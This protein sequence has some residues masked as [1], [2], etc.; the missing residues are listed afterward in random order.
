MWRR[1]RLWVISLVRR[2]RFEDELAG[3]LEF[4]LQAR[5]E[6]WAARGVPAAEARRRARLEFGNPD[7]V[8]AEV[9]DVRIGA[10][11]EH[12]AQDARYGTRMLRKHPGFTAM[13]VLSLAIGIG[14]NTA[15]FSLVNAVLLR[16]VPLQRPE[17][18]VDLYFHQPSF[19]FS[20]LSHPDFEDL[21][22]GTRQVF[23]GIGV[24]QLVPAQLDGDGGIEIVLAEAVTGEYLPVLGVEPLLGRL[25][26]PE[27][28]VAP[29]AHP[30][31]ML[32]HS[33]WQS[34]F[35]ADPKVVGRELRIGS[36]AYT[37]IGV[38]PAAYPGSLRGL[39]PALYAPM[40]MLDELMGVPMLANR[41]GHATFGKAR[42]APG[43]TLV[44]AETAAA[45]VAERLDADRPPDWDPG[46]TFALLPTSEVL[47]YPAL[48]P[49]LRAAAWLLL[50]LV[51][52]VLLLA[53]T[54]LAGFLLAR[55][56]DRRREV[57]VRLAIGASRGALMRQLLT[58][59]TLLSAGG[60][61]LGLGLAVSSLKL[62][63]DADLPIPIP[64][65]LTLD[66]S[67]DATVLAFTIGISVLAGAVLGLVPALQ[68][69]RPDLV[70]T[71]KRETAGGAQAGAVRWR[72]ALVVAQLTV[73]MV[74][75]VGA[76]L[77]LRSFQHTLTVDP[78]FGRDP[79]ALMTVMVPLTRFDPDEGR[80]HVNRLMDRFR[81]LP[82]V[83][84]VGLINNLP[85]TPTSVSWF[86]FTVDGYDPPSAQD[87]Y[88]TD[89][90][91]VAGEFFEAAGIAITEGRRFGPE[92]RSDRPPV[93][94][95][96]AAMAERFWPDGGAVGSLIRRPAEED[97][98]LLV[99]GVVQDVKVRS[100]QEADRFMTYLPLTQNYTLP[101]TFVA[102]TTRGAEATALAMLRVGREVDPDLAVWETKTMAGHLSGN[103]FPAQ[104]AA[105]LTS[106]FGGAALLLAVIGLY[107]VVS[108]TVATRTREV[109][110][111][112]ALGA[113]RT[114][115]VRLLATGGVRLVLVGAG[116][117]LVLSLVV[118]RV[119]GQLLFGVGTADVVA[120]VG[121]PL[122]LG[123]TAFLAAYVPARRA[124]RVNPVSALRAD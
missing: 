115:L 75:L 114:T 29:G 2:R 70:S 68:S 110:I 121:A 48:D 117:G 31:V 73:S 100:L 36:R 55:G 34:G 85:L 9:R 84:S 61:V 63:E 69:T 97:A 28:D 119:L 14:S 16:D 26:G 109:G 98:D 90:A 45:V 52:L 49:Y 106:L 35:G 123:A 47:L 78:G 102:R 88:Q 3:E 42:L 93:A 22:D 27:D 107:G 21:R 82:A 71:L 25:I 57:A 1:W 33:Y 51:G 103:R 79:A 96:S 11:V 10:W 81:G 92:D 8:K 89:Q 44:E 94:I 99:V 105:L 43:V 60:G 124:S 53:C 67:L 5:A 58:E 66:L 112:M 12:V 46:S 76:G 111:R 104:L 32:S 77:F 4:H 101:L 18:L 122:L 54:N 17:E 59:T 23:D 13:A 62:L 113:D 65:S 87:T 6:Q 108:Y 37:I 116:I 20:L 64:V 74:L 38:M 120:F 39:S 72:N 41:A 30:V 95:I 80:Q 19:Q 83:E 15:I 91:T 56:L 86:N 24:T 40:M 50:V 118:S 7:K